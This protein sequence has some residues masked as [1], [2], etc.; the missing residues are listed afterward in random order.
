[1][2]QGA[3]FSLASD[4]AGDQCDGQQLENQTDNARDNVDDVFQTGVVKDGT[5]DIP[6][7]HRGTKLVANAFRQFPSQLKNFFR[8]PV[9]HALARLHLKIGQHFLK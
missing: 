8:Q 4:G 9:D 7:R 1:M 2:R 3:D 5:F 6:R